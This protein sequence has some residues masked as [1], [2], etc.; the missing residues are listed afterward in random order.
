MISKELFQ[1]L[2]DLKAN[3]SKEWFNANKP[4]FEKVNKEFK[5]LTNKL[6]VSIGEF[7]NEIARLT[8]KDCIFRIYRDVR[9]SHDKSPFK[10][11]FGAFLVPGGKKNPRAGY[12]LH[13]E[14]DASFLAGGIY[15]PPADVLKKVRQEIFYNSAEFLEIIQNKNFVKYFKEIEGE[16]LVKAPK[17]FPKDFKHIDLLKFKSYIVVHNIPNQNL[18]ET[19]MFKKSIEIFK[20]MKNLNS[21]LNKAM[22]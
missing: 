3:N 17:D 5:D 8:P 19:N 9:F 13:L 7:D 14:N 2:S 12:Y 6:I 21:F 16:K 1:F 4:T 20:E 22:D 18:F 10:P 15:M 11:N